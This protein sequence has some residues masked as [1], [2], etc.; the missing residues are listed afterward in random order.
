MLTERR[1]SLISPGLLTRVGLVWMLVCAVLLVVNFNSIMT[2]LFPDPDDIMRL[3]QVRDL[4]G[5]QS[6]FDLTQYRAN[7]PG[8]GVPMHWSRLVDTPIALVIVALTPLIGA[9]SA[10]MVALIAVPLVTLGIAML[11]AAR[12]A[13]RLMGEDETVMTCLVIAMSIPL[14]FQFGPMRI[15]HHGWQIVCVLIAMN[16]F[17]A[18]N[19]RLGGSVIG[20]VIAVWLSISI[21]GLPLA[22]AICGVI[23][24][25]WVRNRNDRVWLVATMQALAIT[26]ASVYGLTRGI[27]SLE[28]Y[29]D[30][31]GPVHIAMFGWG[32][33]VMTAMS[34]AEPLPRPAVW[35]GF[36]VAGGGAVAIMLYSVPQCAGGGFSGLDPLVDQYWYQH[37]DEGLPVWRQELKT[38]L[39]YAVAPLIGIFAAINLIGC[40]RDWLRQF[41]IDYTIVL[42]AAFLISL[43]VARTGAVAGALAAI[44]LAWQVG[45]WLRTIRVMRNPAPRALAMVGVSLAMLPALPVLLMGWAMPAQASL[46]STPLSLKVPKASSCQLADSSKLLHALEPGEVF[47]PLDIAPRLLLETDHSVIATGHHRGSDAMRFV[48]ET[49]IGSESDAQAAL[50]ERGTDYVAL[51][52]DLAE[53]LMYAI[54]APESFAAQLVDDSAP[55]WLEPI[56]LDADTSLKVWRIKRD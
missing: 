32:A 1:R 9:A 16:A 14:L 4:I 47:A 20:A 7:A 18:R 21:E 40:S 54:S 22:A 46:G 45:Q 50:L 56:E 5:G 39:Q 10:E 3:V 51:C 12:I 19:A 33:L 13:W 49:S 8:G 44:P 34:K 36:G 26:S 52:P 38:A 53:P 15:D 43:M 2:P 55:D 23:A 29:C 6:W 28:T 24:L 48:I 37:V 30:A 31:I 41:W 25:R 27:G 11:L 42:V 35:M 17:M